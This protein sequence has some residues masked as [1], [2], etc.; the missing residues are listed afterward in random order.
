MER[1]RDRSRSPLD[2]GRP[3]PS[4]STPDSGGASAQLSRHTDSSLDDMEFMQSYC[5]IVEDTGTRPLESSTDDLD[6]DEYYHNICSVVTS[7]SVE[8][9]QPEQER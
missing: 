1:D 8:Q 5:Q 9:R 4:A 2:R 3:S 6:Y 7:S